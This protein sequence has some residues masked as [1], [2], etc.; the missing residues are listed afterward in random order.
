MS[1]QQPPKEA[2]KKLLGSMSQLQASDLHLKV[3]YPPYFRVQGAL[4]GT[5]LQPLPDSAYVE[6]MLEDLF[7]AHRRPE[8]DKR[9]ALDFS[10]TGAGG[11]RFRINMFRAT[12]NTH[13]SIRR[14]QS[15]P[16]TFESLNLP[17]V[18]PQLLSKTTDG[19]ILV[20]GVTAEY[21]DPARCQILGAL[22]A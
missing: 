11:D 20:S 7:P 17:A 19:L 6:A 16:P 8:F 13:A 5:K 15:T 14:V 1:D 21:G 3:G 18:Y 9:G 4:R 10:A 2:M 22:R 12:G